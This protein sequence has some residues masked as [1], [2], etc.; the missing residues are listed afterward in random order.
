MAYTYNLERKCSMSGKRWSGLLG[1]V[2]GG[3][4]LL[5][6][7]KYYEQQGF[8]AIGMPTIILVLGLIYFIRGSES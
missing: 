2:V 1:I 8:V 3:G 4:W 7:L 5:N 6:N